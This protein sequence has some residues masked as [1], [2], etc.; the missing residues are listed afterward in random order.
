MTPPR[1]ITATDADYLALG[2]ALAANN[3][4]AAAELKAVILNRLLNEKEA[5]IAALKAEGEPENV[6][7]INEAKAD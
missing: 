3:A 5:E 7:D 2:K 6:T 1:E 4:S